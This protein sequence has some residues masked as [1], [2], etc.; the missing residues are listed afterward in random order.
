MKRW[1]FGALAVCLLLSGCRLDSAFETA[2]FY[3]LDAG[4]AD[5]MSDPIRKEQKEITGHAGDLS[6]LMH[7]YL[8]GPS[9]EGL[10]SPLPGS[11]T[12]ISIENREGVIQVKLS[13]TRS[14]LTES[15]FSLACAC[16]TLTVSSML[17][18]FFGFIVPP[19]VGGAHSSRSM[20][21]SLRTAPS[22]GTAMNSPVLWCTM[23]LR[24]RA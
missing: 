7:L 8:M 17:T 22:Q 3:Y 24:S 5:R 2:S 11:C 6:Y 21:A 12:L 20:R 15:E 4:Y 16:L 13:D 9:G 23:A 19:M 1:L 18:I 14:S 10:K